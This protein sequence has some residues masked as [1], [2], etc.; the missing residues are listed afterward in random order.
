VT[1][2]PS[3]TQGKWS[4][5]GQSRL[6]TATPST[7]YLSRC[8]TKATRASQPL[9]APDIDPPRDT[10]C[11][12]WVGVFCAVA[13]VRV[14]TVAQEKFSPFLPRQAAVTRDEFQR[15]GEEEIDFY[16]LAIHT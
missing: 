13:D 2:R 1:Q 10:D 8:T 15:N 4:Y 5:V 3:A 9:P 14:T 16:I 12:V 11:A 7:V 6:Y